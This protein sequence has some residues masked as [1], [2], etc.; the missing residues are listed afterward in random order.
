MGYRLHVLKKYQVEYGTGSFSYKTDNLAKMVHN[1]FDDA[2]PEWDDGET[3]SYELTREPVQAYVD[4]LRKL[5]P[6][7]INKYFKLESR[8]NRYTNKEVADFWQEVLDTSDPENDFI[9]LE[10]F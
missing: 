3:E 9:R 8:D 1:E 4:K 5:A 10:W 2:Y 7:G 6:N